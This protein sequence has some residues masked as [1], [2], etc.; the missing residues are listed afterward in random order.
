M[1]IDYGHVAAVG[2]GGIILFPDWNFPD[3]PIAP[4]DIKEGMSILGQG[5]YTNIISIT[6]TADTQGD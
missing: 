4:A 6:G 1:L 2:E 3:Q 5:G